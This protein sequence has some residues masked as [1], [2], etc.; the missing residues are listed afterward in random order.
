MP[1]PIIVGVSPGQLVAAPT[2]QVFS[3]RI[4]RASDLHDLGGLRGVTNQP[5]FVGEINKGAG[6]LTLMLDH[7]PNEL[8]FG[9]LI[10]VNYPSGQVAGL[11]KYEGVNSKLSTTKSYVLV[12]I[13]LVSEMTDADFVA[14]YSSDTTQPG[15]PL[16][17]TTFD[18]PILAAIPRTL[19]C[20][21]G[22]I[23]NDGNKYSYVFNNARCADTLSQAITF[24][25]TGWWWYCDASGVITLANAS[26]YTHVWT[27]GREVE[28]G[29]WEED[30]H[31]LVN[32]Q[33]VIGGQSPGSTIAL[34]AFAVDT[35]PG[36]PYSVPSI[37]RRT[38]NSYSDSSILDQASVNAVAT[39]LLAYGERVSKTKKL[40]LSGYKIRRPQ[41][42]DACKLRAPSPDPTSLTNNMSIQGPFLITKVTE[43]G[44]TY[45][46]DVEISADMVV[47]IT[48]IQP[49]LQ[50]DQAMQKL[51]Q[52]PPRSAISPDGTVGSIA[53]G[54]VGGAAATA[55]LNATPGTPVGLAATTGID[56]IAQAN[57]AY[58][59]LTWSAN[60]ASDGVSNYLL[61]YRKSTDP[62]TA[63]S[64]YQERT[65]ALGLKIGGLYQGLTYTFQLA[66]INGAG[67]QGA[68]ATVSQLTAQ[69]TTPPAVP[70]NLSA[71][72][73]PRGA[74][75]SWSPG[76]E[77]GGGTAPDLQGYSVQVA[78]DG[79]GTGWA[80]VTPSGAYS[81]NTSLV[82]TAPNGTPEG[83]ILYFR[84]AAVDWSGN[85]S[86]YCSQSPAIYTDGV[87]FAELTVGQLNAY[88]LITATGG[89]STRSTSPGTA[90]GPGV[91]ITAS[92]ITLY[93]GTTNNYG[94]GTGVTGQLNATNGN[95]FFSGTVG[96]SQIQGVSGGSSGSGARMWLDLKDTTAGVGPLLDVNDG[97][98]DRVQV[99]NLAANGNSPA[100]YGLR[101]NDST[102]SPIF[103][104]LGLMKVALVIGNISFA[105]GTQGFTTSWTAVTGTNTGSFTLSRT[106]NL[107]IHSF[108]PFY[109]SGG[110]ASYGLLRLALLNNSGTD[111]QLSD[112]AIHT[113]GS[114]VSN[115]APYMYISGLAAGTYSAQFEY[116]MDAG[117]TTTFTIGSGVGIISTGGSITV[118]QLGQ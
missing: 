28:E 45:E 108:S 99:G 64:Y 81:L 38:A 82:Y 44:A 57:N 89:L 104:S 115:G 11:W 6:A 110:T 107:I 51:L 71:Y 103:D 58:V 13:P 18:T 43:Y 1:N 84:V 14:N 76:V 47:P 68:W 33:P 35:N 26:P 59:S 92:G 5:I 25:S 31:S 46:Y 102:G 83:T 40:K 90:T 118:I 74:L 80:Q 98:V 48:V 77:T 54:V 100:Q 24:G 27:L 78:I 109:T 95:A 55:P 29:E 34:T 114:G 88:G 73:T 69:D 105:T 86:A 91:D 52:N 15:P 32:A 17:T 65:N 8:T 3:Y 117:A 97:T 20:S 116:R 42:G 75:V 21:A 60:S 9:N 79:T 53:N 62:D 22:S 85:I 66:A 61:R 39:S 113:N 41:P 94:G 96:A 2:D 7:Y 49:T 70:T 87:T 50:A 10:R 93:D 30:I 19:H 56:N 112:V 72:R 16:G 101:V 23:A 4:L 67:V 111:I 36:N 37:G 106:Q 63:A 12:L